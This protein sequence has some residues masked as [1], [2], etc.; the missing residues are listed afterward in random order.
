MKPPA[1][2]V[3][4]MMSSTGH[5]S[6]VALSSAT[7]CPART[8]SY[9][10]GSCCSADDLL[11][12]RKVPFSQLVSLVRRFSETANGALDSEEPCLPGVPGRLARVPDPR[13]CRG[14]LLGLRRGPEEQAGAGLLRDR[15]AGEG[16]GDRQGLRRED[17]GAAREGRRGP[18]QGG[19]GADE[20]G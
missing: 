9:L 20:G 3:E 19:G 14:R 5:S 12:D 6:T 7:C 1:L 10:V 4:W 15:V 18:D 11:A 2:V 17:H 13:A 16:Q 8:R